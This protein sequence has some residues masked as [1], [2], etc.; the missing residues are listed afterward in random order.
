MTTDGTSLSRRP[1]PT[2]G[3]PPV[4]KIRGVLN[5]LR[6]VT[7]HDLS[8]TSELQLFKTRV[9]ATPSTFCKEETP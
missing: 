9:D 7:R 6:F 3:Y 2:P 5:G 1:V 8:V 4:R